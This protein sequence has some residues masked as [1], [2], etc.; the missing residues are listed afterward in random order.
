MVSILDMSQRKQLLEAVSALVLPAVRLL[1]FKPIP[2]AVNEL[3]DGG[4]RRAFPFGQMRLLGETTS[5]LL[6]FQLDKYGRPAIRIQF[7]EVSNAHFDSQRAEGLGI[8]VHHLPAYFECYRHP[9]WLA[10]FKVTAPPW[11]STSQTDH[12]RVANELLKEVPGIA[13][14]I[15]E[16]RATSRQIRRIRLDS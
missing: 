9:L 6:E 12:K 10:W 1:G 14:I 2:Y 13:S 16:G 15:N 5:W 4:Y 7:G 3:A 8:G 11:R